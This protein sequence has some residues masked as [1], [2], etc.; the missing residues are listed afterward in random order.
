MEAKIIPLKKLPAVPIK[1]LYAVCCQEWANSP[2][3]EPDDEVAN[4]NVDLPSVKPSQ[5]KIEFEKI[6]REE[7][8][9]TKRARLENHVKQLVDLNLGQEYLNHLRGLYDEP[10]PEL[11]DLF[12]LH[13]QTYKKLSKW[14]GLLPKLKENR[15]EQLLKQKNRFS[16]E[17]TA[18]EEELFR[19]LRNFLHGRH[20]SIIKAE[21][22]KLFDKDVAK[23]LDEFF[24]Q[25]NALYATRQ[26]L[27]DPKI[28]LLRFAK[29]CVVDNR[30]LIQEGLDGKPIEKAPELFQ[31]FLKKVVRDQIGDV[32]LTK[33]DALIEG[34]KVADHVGA[35]LF[36]LLNLELSYGKN[37]ELLK[38]LQEKQV[39][40][41]GLALLSQ[42]VQA[43]KEKF[44]LQWD[45]ALTQA[46]IFDQIRFQVEPGDNRSIERLL[47]EIA[48]EANLLTSDEKLDVLSEMVSTLS[49]R[50][51]FTALSELKA[52][53]F[54]QIRTFGL[55]PDEEYNAA[56]LEAFKNESNPKDHL[57]SLFLKGIDRLS[58]QTLRATLIAINHL[59]WKMD[60]LLLL[61]KTVKGL[62]EGPNKTHCLRRIQKFLVLNLR[63]RSE[64]H[65]EDLKKT[66]VK[67]GESQTDYVTK[68]SSVIKSTNILNPDHQIAKFQLWL[69]L[70]DH[71]FETVSFTDA[72]GKLRLRAHKDAYDQFLNKMRLQDSEK[73]I[74]EFN[75]WLGDKF[76][77]LKGGPANLKSLDQLE[78]AEAVKKL[79]TLYWRGE[80]TYAQ[81]LERL[82]N[83]PLTD[84][85][86]KR[87]KLKFDDSMIHE[88]FY[89]AR[90]EIEK[91]QLEHEK[92]LS[93]WLQHVMTAVVTKKDLEG[94]FP[95]EATL[96]KAIA[97]RKIPSFCSR[98]S[99][100]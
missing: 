18:A 78:K 71:H 44:E 38:I 54:K 22:L 11:A 85:V 16:A 53:Q 82:E 32:D 29:E 45:G 56:L 51:C 31:D 41:S 43:Q 17:A 1:D 28:D 60:Q 89:E 90:A 55:F 66:R 83:H 19:K 57:P 40:K 10:E 46:Q 8:D 4:E 33:T 59:P 9:A 48:A 99:K 94:I 92:K 5:S 35:H 52:L 77:D 98:S 42:K 76:N 80:A 36:L 72:D 6:A 87:L 65:K 79:N 39:A 63:R 93:E 23:Y 75:K 97:E 91:N 62:E 13:V 58:S 70:L 21:C 2:S 96:T 15:I 69:K 37:V 84:E 27:K 61:Y 30:H 68:I 74:G 81:I 95:D 34:C 73:A 50:G 67:I 7:W 14:E 25:I 3:F 64:S 26:V 20:L 47:T 86:Q 49:T 88:E 100:T 24:Q 12:V